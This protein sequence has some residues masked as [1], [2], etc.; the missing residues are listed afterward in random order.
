MP[1][2]GI[3]WVVLILEIYTLMG[4]V[5]VG[6]DFGLPAF[7]RPAYAD[8]TGPHVLLSIYYLP[9]GSLLFPG[10]GGTHVERVYRFV[11]GGIVAVA[12]VSALVWI[13]GFMV[14]PLLYLLMIVGALLLVLALPLLLPGR[15]R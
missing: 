10:L 12:V 5:L 13:L 1:E 3:E 2:S 7:R 8:R 11:V 6:Q 15:A 14:S 4:L 9:I